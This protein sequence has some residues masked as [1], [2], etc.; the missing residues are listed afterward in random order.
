MALGVGIVGT[1][2]IAH[3][4][5]RA[6]REAPEAELVAI[7]DVSEAALARFGEAYKVARRY[8][9]LERM[10]HEEQIDILVICTW[11]DSHA[12]L[13]I[14]AAQTGRVR[15]ILCEKPISAT[16]AECEAMIESARAHGVLLAEGFKF[17]HHPCHLQAKE[18]IEAGEIGQVMLIR[19]TFTVAV[20][21]RNLRPDR[22]WRFNREKRGG[23]T[24]DLGCY[25]IHHARF[26]AGGEPDVIHAQGEYGR[27]S[28][29]PESVAVQ[30]GFPDEISAQCVFSF[31]YYSSQ[32]FE[33]YGSDGYMRMDLAW[34]NEDQP[35]ALEIRRNDGRERTIRFAPVHQ[36]TDQLRHLCDCL[37]TG[38]PHR[39]P[40]E[41][42][43]GNMRVLDAVH[44]SLDA[45]RSARAE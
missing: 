45:G 10:L 19:S 4:H 26:I 39:I 11:G 23:A 8:T 37:Q 17:R 41:N 13:S 5:G 38:S 40:P 28:D 18:L 9:D 30:L 42:S 7:C 14:R 16:A 24:Y 36:F 21:P 3:C 32:E 44:A 25:C 31:R 15:A 2:G 29:V 27:R 33:V 20:D 34:N 22:N 6:T 12:D 35:V 43:L 1:G